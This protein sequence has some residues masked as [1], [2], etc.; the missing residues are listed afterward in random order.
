MYNDFEYLYM[1]RMQDSDAIEFMQKKFSK[2]V[3]KKAH[4][5]YKSR[6][7]IGLTLDDLY[8][9]GSIGLHNALFGFNEDKKVG[10][11][12]YVQLCVESS[13][14]SAIRK[15][16]GKAYSMLNPDFSLDMAISEDKSLFLHEVIGDDSFASD[17]EKMSHYLDA[18]K[19]EEEV[20]KL[21]NPLELDVYKMRDLGFSYRDIA[22]NFNL[23]EKKVDNI[24]QKIKRLMVKASKKLL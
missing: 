14:K 20:M 16:N 4:I 13:I 9:E 19:V 21:L 3:W 22:T 8:Q 18:K 23:T 6:F 7:P 11:A 2:L 1:V 12:H 24:L 10:L 5:L 15:S 17:P